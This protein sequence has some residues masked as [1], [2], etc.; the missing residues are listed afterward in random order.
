MT[1][2]LGIGLLFVPA[3]YALNYY[4]AD[5]HQ[6]FTLTGIAIGVGIFGGYAAIVAVYLGIAAFSPRPSSASAAVDASITDGD[7]A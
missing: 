2:V 3:G 5:A 4:I 1:I 6:T 7:R